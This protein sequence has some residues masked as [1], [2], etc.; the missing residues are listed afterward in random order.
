MHRAPPIFNLDL[1]KKLLPAR[2][3]TYNSELF[4]N[5][6]FHSSQPTRKAVVTALKQKNNSNL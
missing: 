5:T 3:P 2:N 6:K 1:Q 4:I